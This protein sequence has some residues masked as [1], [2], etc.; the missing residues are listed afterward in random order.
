[1]VG[2]PRWESR[3]AISSLAGGIAL[4]HDPNSGHLTIEKGASWR[5]FLS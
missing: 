2:D 1:M 4:P 5:S 3:M